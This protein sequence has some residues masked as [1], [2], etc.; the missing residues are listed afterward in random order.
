MCPGS[1]ATWGV[2][3]DV[4]V[5][6]GEVPGRATCYGTVVLQAE[7]SPDSKPSANSRPMSTFIRP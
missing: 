4:R 2:S 5:P 7:V 1:L 6:A 3:C